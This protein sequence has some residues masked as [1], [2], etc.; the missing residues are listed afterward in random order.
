MKMVVVEPCF[1]CCRPVRKRLALRTRGGLLAEILEKVPFCSI[2]CAANYGLI[3]GPY[4][5]AKDWTWCP[6]GRYWHEKQAECC[7]FCTK[8]KEGAKP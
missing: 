4:R 5:I 2:R 1:M 7:L 6:V 3:Y 8:G